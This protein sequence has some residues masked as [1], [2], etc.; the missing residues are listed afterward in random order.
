MAWY[1]NQRREFAKGL[2]EVA[3]QLLPV[4]NEGRRD[5]RQEENIV[6]VG[7]SWSR[8]RASKSRYILV[9]KELNSQGL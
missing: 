5:D 3:I 4:C 2:G 8:G 1:E 6:K 7:Q 9:R